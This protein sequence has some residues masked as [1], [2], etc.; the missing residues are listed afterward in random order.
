MKKNNTLYFFTAT[1][2]EW[3]H[4]LK[5]NNYKV[6]ITD[7]LKFLCTAEK[8]KV[9]A[10]VIMPNHIHL[11]WKILPDNNYSDIQRD[12]LKFTAKEIISRLKKDSP[13]Y[14]KHFFVG[15]RDRNYQIWERSP[16]SIEILSKEVAEQ[17]INYIH[18]NPLTEKWKLA[19]EPQHYKFSSAKFYYEGIDEFGFLEN[20]MLV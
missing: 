9:C 5:D 2:L 20:Y 10:F 8:I 19:D 16:L 15:A 6:I 7:T 4:L 12:F 1:I 11:V 18:K 13:E 14:L 3:K 17:K